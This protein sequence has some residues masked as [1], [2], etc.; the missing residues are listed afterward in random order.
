MYRIIIY[1]AIGLND[2]SISLIPKTTKLL[3]MEIFDCWLKKSAKVL[4]ARAQSS[5][6]VPAV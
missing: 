3:S 6:G 4:Q 5:P 1:K 2:S